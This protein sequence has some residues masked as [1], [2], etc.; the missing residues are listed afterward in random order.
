MRNELDRSREEYIIIK[1]NF[2]EINKHYKSIFDDVSEL[3]HSLCNEK[4]NNNKL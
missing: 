2:E 1:N 3:K 4:N